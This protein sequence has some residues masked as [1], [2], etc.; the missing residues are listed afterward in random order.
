MCNSLHGN[1]FNIRSETSVHTFHMNVLTC[2]HNTLFPAAAF[3]FSLRFAGITPGWERSLSKKFLGFYT[4]QIESVTSV[5]ETFVHGIL[6]V[7]LLIFGI[8]P[9]YNI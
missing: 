5:P 7:G 2:L 3:H 6:H 4:V 1:G 9:L 8:C